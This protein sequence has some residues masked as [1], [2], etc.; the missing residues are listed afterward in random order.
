MLTHA[1]H[2]NNI[3]SANVLSMVGLRRCRRCCSSGGVSYLLLASAAAVSPE[4]TAALIFQPT[5]TPNAQQSRILLGTMH[6]CSLLGAPSSRIASKQRRFATSYGSPRVLEAGAREVD[7]ATATPARMSRGCWEYE[8]VCTYP[9]LSKH[10][11]RAPL[12]SLPQALCL[13][14]PK[15]FPSSS[16]AHKAVNHRTILV[17]R[18]SAVNRMKGESKSDTGDHAFTTT[19]TTTT[20]GKTSTQLQEG[21]VISVRR[22]LANA[23]CYPQSATKYCDPPPEVIARSLLSIEIL[24]KDDCIAVV[25]K[26][27]SLDTIGEK[28]R[29]LKSV[30]P[31]ILRPPANTVLAGAAPL[32]LPLPVHRLD[33]ATSGCVLVAK[34]K[35]AMSQCSQMFASREG[36]QK[37]YVAIVCGVPELVNDSASKSDKVVE[38]EGEEFSTVDYPIE[39]KDAVTLWRTVATYSSDHW[40]TISLVH[41]IPKTGRNH[42]LRRHLRYCLGSPIVGDA[43]YGGRVWSKAEERLETDMGM[44]LCSNSLSFDCGNSGVS[45]TDGHCKDQRSLCVQIPLPEKFYSIMGSSIENVEI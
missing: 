14:D 8:K 40:G 29:D 27:E 12:M 22:R 36:I 11:S 7:P 5:P 21:D 34:T 18:A 32:R 44:F 2:C 1:R 37:S 19:A 45:S 9:P 17:T 23:S 4:G 6:S 31:F 20:I 16:Q 10:T 30:L 33:R 24:Y 3:R 39:G 28:R 15:R 43:K 38:I 13:L 35:C 25:N 41:L 42:Q 26:P